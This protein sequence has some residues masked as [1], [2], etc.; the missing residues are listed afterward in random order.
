[1]SLT[2]SHNSILASLNLEGLQHSK[3]CPADSLSKPHSQTGVS[4]KPT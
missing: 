3:K 1:M 2:L 4:D